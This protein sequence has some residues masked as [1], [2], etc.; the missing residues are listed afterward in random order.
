MNK[1]YIRGFGKQVHSSSNTI[2]EVIPFMN[3]LQKT[4]RCLDSCQG[5]QFFNAVWRDDQSCIKVATSLKFTP[6]TWHIAIKCYCFRSYMVQSLSSLSKQ[7]INLWTSWVAKASYRLV[8]FTMNTI[9]GQF[10]ATSTAF[11]QEN[12]TALLSQEF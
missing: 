10:F 7:K 6:C 3:L 2:N 9:C 1:D 8:G 5:L 11:F 12:V 4:A